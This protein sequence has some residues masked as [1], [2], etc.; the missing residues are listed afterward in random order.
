MLHP[1]FAIR[2][3]LAFYV[4]PLRGDVAST[5]RDTLAL[6]FY[7][8]PL[9]GDVASTLRDTLGVGFLCTPASR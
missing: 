9:R 2:R 3:A 6:A 8:P 7:V 4:P 5:L 1:R